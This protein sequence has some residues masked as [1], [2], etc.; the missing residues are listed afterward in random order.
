MLGMA[1]DVTDRKQA[2]LKLRESEQR[3]R[4]VANT[5][6]VMA[7]TVGAGCDYE[8]FLSRACIAARRGN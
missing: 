5:T 7:G 2:E 6:P 1:V 8:R 3:F 4:L